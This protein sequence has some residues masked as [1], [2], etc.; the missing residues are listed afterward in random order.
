MFDT[1]LTMSR[2]AAQDESAKGPEKT[3]D[4]DDTSD[5]FAD[6]ETSSCGSSD[7]D[8]MW[9]N[10][11][12]NKAV[13]ECPRRSPILQGTLSVDNYNWPFTACSHVTSFMR[14]TNLWDT[15]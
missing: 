2:T 4:I 7:H 15:S 14:K 13:L 3:S 10:T 6:V 5:Y 12:K 11:S 1:D 8:N 9:T